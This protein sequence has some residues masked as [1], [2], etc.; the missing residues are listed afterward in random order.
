MTL[1]RTRSLIT[2]GVAALAASATAAA[3]LTAIPASAKP[4][5]PASSSVVLVQCGGGS[6]VK[7]S[8]TEL[9]GCMQSGEFVS[10]M[11]WKVWQS[12]AFGSGK[13]EVNNC[14]PSCAGGKYIKYPV[15]LVLWGA[16]SWPHHSGRQYFSKLTWIFTAKR[17]E[18]A[19][20]TS[21]TYTL[22]ANGFPTG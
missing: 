14:T 16:K 11:S 9:P 1:T 20:A 10:G 21:Q 15:L 18:G 12:N 22:T 13:L 2:A 3:V 17:P 8:T 6:A 7:P 4:T 5:A 19:N